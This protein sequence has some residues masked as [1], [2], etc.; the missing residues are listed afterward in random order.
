MLKQHNEF[1]KGLLLGS[2]L[3]F[4]SMA[5]WLAYFIR[6]YS[7]IFP[8]PEP[9][10]FRH[11]LIGWLAIL[12][13]WTAVFELCGVHRPRRISTHRHEIAELIKASALALL[14]FLG[15][16]FL[17]RE[18]ALSRAVV[19]IFW[20]SSL[21]FLNLSH[22]FFREGLRFLRRRGHNLRRVVI[23][24]MPSQAQALL[25]RF[26]T[27]RHLGMRV[28][29]L[30]L[31]E[32]DDGADFARGVDLIRSPDELSRLVC[33]GAVDQVFVALPLAEASRLKDVQAWLGDEP[34]ALYFV[35]DLGDFATLRSSFEE[36]DGLQI[37]SLQSSPHNGWNVLSKRFVDIS[38]GG[39]AL[40][41]FAPVM[42]AVAIAI[43]CSSRG[44]VLYR[45]ERM[46]LDGRRFQMLKFR[47]MV[48]DAEKMTGPVWADDDDPR[49]TPLGRWLRQTSLDELPQLINVLRG[50]MSL[51][52]PRPERPPLIDEF[53]KS[54]PKYMLRHKVKAGMTGWAQIHGWR[55]NTSL[56]TRIEYDLD[57]I[58][59]W[60]LTR[61]IKILF[62]T[63]L[64]GFRN[65]R[66][67]HS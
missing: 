48:A 19:I 45:Q 30:Y 11:Y 17:I 24:G 15:I 47:T 4:V 6:F 60:S 39:I 16:V 51:V 37:I 13:V 27:Y 1:F 22:I 56:A 57:Y 18:L 53:R 28:A 55:G 38:V 65:N 52:G 23:V 61:D 63:L 35:P 21:I 40:L 25:S 10:L 42:A 12:V 31:M 59:N 5:W 64:G 43:K 50:E 14:I 49:V 29:G 67:S 36:F 26:K 54:I 3:Y 34:V 9:F 62:L 20:F 44:P 33:S 32:P 7:S 46:G 2:D 58:E 8:E 66:T 41:I